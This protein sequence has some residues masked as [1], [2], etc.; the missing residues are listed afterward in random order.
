[1]LLPQSVLRSWSAMFMHQIMAGAVVADFVTVV[2]SICR[3]YI[4]MMRKN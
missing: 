1:M 4:E 3:Q 2:G